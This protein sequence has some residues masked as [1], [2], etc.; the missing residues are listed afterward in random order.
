VNTGYQT[1]KIFKDLSKYIDI[2]KNSINSEAYKIK[3][4]LTKGITEHFSDQFLTTSITQK[5]SKTRHNGRSILKGLTLTFK[6]VS[7]SRSPEILSD[8]T[9]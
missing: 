1:Q 2:S 5:A 8:V 7:P 9:G 4:Y 3:A 6:T